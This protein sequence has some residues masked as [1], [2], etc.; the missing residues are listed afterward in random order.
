MLS[1]PRLQDTTETPEKLLAIG[2]Y[3]RAFH[4]SSEFETK[5]C[6]KI[7]C[8]AIKPG[9]A[10]LSKCEKLSNE[11]QLIQSYGHWCLGAVDSAL[12]ILN[13]LSGLSAKKLDKL[14]R[15][16]AEV[17]I[18][19]PPG[20]KQLKD[21]ENISLTYETV[22]PENFSN[23]FLKKCSSR[24]LIL[25]LGAYG[26]HLPRNFFDVDCPTAFWVGDHDFFYATR[27][28]DFS[29]ATILVVNSAG[30]HS[31]LNQCYAARVASFPGHESY[32]KSDQF[33]ASLENK[34]FDIGYTGRAFVPY[35]RDKAQ[36]LYRLAILDD[37]DLEI[38]IREGYLPEDDFMALMRD[39]KFVPLFWR[40]AGGIQTRAID[41]LRQG[42]NVLSPELLTTGELVGGEEEGFLSVYSDT[43]EAL[44]LDHLK[45]PKACSMPVGSFK[46]LFWSE[47][48]R[49]HRFI[50]FCLFQS[51]FAPQLKKVSNENL[52]L[53]A[54]LRGY[55]PNKAIK[56][57]VAVAKYNIT[58]ED[59]TAAHY[60]FAACAA[61]YAGTVG[62]GNQKLGRYS[63][64]LFALG[65]T[66]YPENLALKFNTARALWTFG[67][68]AE[69]SIIFGEIARSANSLQYNPKDALLSH[70]MHSLAKMFS[71]GDF[72]QVA[73]KNTGQAKIM[74]Q[75]CALTYLGVLA[76]ETNQ[77]EESCAFFEKAISLSSVNVAAYK[78]LTKVL[79]LLSV[80]SLKV[81]QTFYRAIE[82]YPPN[83]MELLP[84][85][86]TAELSDG[87]HAEAA[88]L[89]NQ[90][91][92]FHLRVRQSSGD[93]IPLN[94][95]SLKTVI[96]Q[97]HLIRN[98]IGDAFD[99]IL[100]NAVH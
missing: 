86:V 73:L 55:A 54:E 49:D 17:L 31:E 14:I 27:Q 25:S 81:L 30:E 21:F 99:Q 18:C 15:N 47:P 36:F 72:L 1:L 8:G 41:A 78:W 58:A 4:L 65:I 20:I 77:L 35:M 3:A 34:K 95:V 23:S 6:A 28:A 50:K 37:P 76:F 24:D 90:W 91:V 51:L 70:R 56:I 38:T 40:Y 85:G 53:P 87:R 59:K 61:F 84:F 66:A 68:K 93:L 83:L 10:D 43:P 64:E 44:V 82:L 62:E 46:D 16:G 94:Q 32:G 79:A 48:S 22:E 92:L 13:E 67:A 42:S 89:L 52:P 57:Y 19:T 11:S 97:R 98:W 88:S 9:L 60:N 29:R 5:A 100:K 45:N 7:M 69:S 39:S 80:N 26:G 71:Y 74:I 63:L 12:E 2:D 96:E 33:P 75:S